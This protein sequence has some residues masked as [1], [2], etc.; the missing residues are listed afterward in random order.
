MDQ[1]SVCRVGL[2]KEEEL[3]GEPRMVIMSLS[4]AERAEGGF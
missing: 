2:G 1:V 3:P 4:K